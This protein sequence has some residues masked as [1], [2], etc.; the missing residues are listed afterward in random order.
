MQN[1]PYLASKVSWRLGS[2]LV[3]SSQFVTSHWVAWRSHVALYIV[4]YMYFHLFIEPFYLSGW[5]HETGT[6]VKTGKVLGCFK[7]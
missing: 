3:V 1:I 7:K 5:P 4:P 2:D 6:E